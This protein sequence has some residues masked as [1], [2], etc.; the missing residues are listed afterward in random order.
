ERMGCKAGDTVVVGDVEF[1][2]V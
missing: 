2:Y 1:D